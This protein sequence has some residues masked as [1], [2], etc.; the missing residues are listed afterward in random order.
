MSTAMVVLSGGQDSTTCLFWAKT[1]F[2][3]VYAITFNYGQKHNIELA[4]AEKV[5]AMANV[6]SFQIIDVPNILKSRS[7][8][9]DPNI[10]LET[11]NNYDEM[12]NIIGNRIEKTFVPMRN[13]FFLTL[14]SNYA[15]EKDCFNLVTGVCQGDNA[16][17]PD[18]RQSFITQQEKTINEALGITNFI[19]HTPLMDLSKAQIVLL[20][21][22]LEGCM[23]AMAYSH[24]CYAGVYP[25]CGE[26]H[27]C[28]LRAYGFNE[29]GI[30]DPL[31]LRNAV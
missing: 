12:D 30:A 28:V 27:S 13:A 26:C 5:S 8:L 19:I 18:C 1:K 4:S 3:K 21:N 23:S 31:I 25:P 29:A 24:T 11:Y 14:A 2:D 22:N 6:D 17:Y 10:E 7:P 16:N 9:T 20:A 15:L